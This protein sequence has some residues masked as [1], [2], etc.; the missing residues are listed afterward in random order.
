MD[1]ISVKGGEQ[2]ELKYQSNLDQ[3]VKEGVSTSV[4]D[5]TIEHLANSRVMVVDGPF[6]NGVCCLPTSPSNPAQAKGK[7]K[8]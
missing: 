8:W 5:I 1:A 2:W 4:K 7:I 3:L 6:P